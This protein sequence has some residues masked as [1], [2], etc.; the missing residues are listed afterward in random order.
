L[1]ANSL[2]LTNPF[3][4]FIVQVADHQAA[5]LESLKFLTRIVPVI[6]THFVSC[7]PTTPIGF[8]KFYEDLIV[9]VENSLAMVAVNPEIPSAV[10]FSETIAKMQP[11]G[12]ASTVSFLYWEQFATYC[13]NELKITSPAQI[14]S[15]I[16]LLSDSGVCH[17]FDHPELRNIVILDGQMIEKY[18]ASIIQWSK[19]RN[20]AVFTLAD[21]RQCWKGVP[22]QIQ[23]FMIRLLNLMEVCFPIRGKHLQNSPIPK[24]FLKS[25]LFYRWQ[26]EN[27]NLDYPNIITSQRTPRSKSSS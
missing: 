26:E 10:K 24:L 8:A 6:S 20:K 17:W 27:S 11:S 1:I 18:V 4:L 22:A 19:Q 23:T 5:I 25:K 7:T 2:T 15:V 14:N 9:H 16:S 21:L 3:P 13:V 12:T